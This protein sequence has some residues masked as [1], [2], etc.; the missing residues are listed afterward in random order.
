MCHSRVI[1]ILGILAVVLFTVR[2]T[3]FQFAGSTEAH[4]VPVK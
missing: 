2:L 1:P 4:G 3:E